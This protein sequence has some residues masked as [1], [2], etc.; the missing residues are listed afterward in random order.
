MLPKLTHFV[1][2]TAACE[3]S[4]VFP[5]GIFREPAF[6]HPFA[7]FMQLPDRPDAWAAQDAQNCRQQWITD[8]KGP[9]DDQNPRHKKNRPDPVR[10]II[11]T[12]Y[13]NRMKNPDNQKRDNT[14]NDTFKI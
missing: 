4:V 7:L 1:E 6:F 14:D 13:D 10:K 9:D 12:L 8:K 2:E 11:F 3:H 5:F